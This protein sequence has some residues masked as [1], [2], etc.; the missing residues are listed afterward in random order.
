VG[1]LC[2]LRLEDI[3]DEGEAAFFKIRRPAFC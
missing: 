2:A 1:E 3:E